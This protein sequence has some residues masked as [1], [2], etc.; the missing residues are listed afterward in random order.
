MRLVRRMLLVIVKAHNLCQ[1]LARDLI[2]RCHLVRC[3][4]HL[5]VR[6]V[7][8]DWLEFRVF[9]AIHWLDNFEV[10]INRFFFKDGLFYWCKVFLIRQIYVVE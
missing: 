1:E 10:I 2:Q 7:P 8:D 3:D 5:D 9:D 6:E 4:R